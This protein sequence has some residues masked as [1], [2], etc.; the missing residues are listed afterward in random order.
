[1]DRFQQADRRGIA[2]NPGEQYDYPYPWVNLGSLTAALAATPA[3]GARDRTT[4]AALITAGTVLEL[5]PP[6]NEFDGK[7]IITEPNGAISYEIRLRSTGAENDSHVVDILT[8]CNP[9]AT[10]HY[11]R[12]ATITGAQGQQAAT[13]GY[14]HDAVVGTNE[15]WLTDPTDVP[16]VAQANYIGSYLFNVHGAVSIV[17]APVTIPAGIL[18]IDARRFS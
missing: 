8:A 5:I 11:T 12:R 13:A 17:F 3:V 9:I 15:A 16:A 18:Y 10:E 7:T 1:M 2:A 14:F 4:I 6:N